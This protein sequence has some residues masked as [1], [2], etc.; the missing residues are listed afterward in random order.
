MG[1]RTVIDSKSEN[2]ESNKKFFENL[3]FIQNI[4]LIRMLR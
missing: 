3:E 2:L 1:D 4:F